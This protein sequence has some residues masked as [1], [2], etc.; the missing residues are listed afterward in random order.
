LA[1][2]LAVLSVIPSGNLLFPNA[3]F[4]QR[5]D[6]LRNLPTLALLLAFT[7][8]IPALGKPVPDL[9]F[10]DLAGHNQRLNDVH[11]S[12]TVISFWAT[13]CTPCREE[14]PR[15]SLLSQQY[16]AQGVR[17]IAISVDNP[18]DFAKIQPFL[19]QQHISLNVW[20]GADIGT[21]DRLGLGDVVPATIVLDS[22]GEIIGRISGEARDPDVTAYLDW[23]LHNRQGPAP[24][25]MLKRY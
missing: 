8:P 9:K 6:M 18:K 1:F 3:S 16:A 23:L 2:A 10:H 4:H 13:W 24:P 14:L 25:P 21:L 12:I 20:T 22:N 17:F 5:I 19:Q 11:G 15:L 7:A